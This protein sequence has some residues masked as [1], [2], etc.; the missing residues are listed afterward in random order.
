MHTHIR[1]PINRQLSFNEIYRLAYTMH[2]F[3]YKDIYT[4]TCEQAA[5][6]TAHIYL[7]YIHTNTSTHTRT[8]THTHTHPSADSSQSTTYTD[9]HILCIHSHIDT[10]THTHTHTPVS[11]RFFQQRT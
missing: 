9:S 3:G 7:A 11:R 4:H 6:S 5:G 2:A 8:H 1:V 10:H